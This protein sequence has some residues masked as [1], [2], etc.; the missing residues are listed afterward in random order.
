MNADVDALS[1]LLREE[2]NQHIEADSVC[3]MIS[4][5]S[6]G[7]TLIEAYSCKVQA[8]ETLDMLQDPK[9]MPLKDW[10]M[11]QSQESDKEIKYL[12]CT[13]KLKAQKVYLQDPQIMKQYLRQCSYLVLHKG[14]CYR[15]LTP[16]KG[17]GM[18]YS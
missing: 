10:I 4:Q 3:A 12:I 6:Q 14:V 8:T 16:F 13:N 7:T 11:A 5:A 17:D 2:H 1:H 15:Q 9:T 18:P